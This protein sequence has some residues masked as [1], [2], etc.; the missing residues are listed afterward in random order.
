[1][2]S[3]HKYTSQKTEDEK[4][5]AWLAV[6]EAFSQYDPQKAQLPAFVKSKVNFALR[7]NNK[8]IARRQSREVSC[9]I[10][11]DEEEVQVIDTLADKTD[12]AEQVERDFIGQELIKALNL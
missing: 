2:K 5:I 9:W 3:I 12:I 6:C 4:Q 7:N 8:R 1:M 10:V 11:E